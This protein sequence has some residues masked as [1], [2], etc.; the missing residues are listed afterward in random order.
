MNG[1]VHAAGSVSTYVLQMLSAADAQSN[2]VL[3]DTPVESTTPYVYSTSSHYPPSLFAAR[4]VQN[5][6][7]N[8]NTTGNNSVNSGN[9]GN[10]T[11]FQYE[12]SSQYPTTVETPTTTTM[13]H[14]SFGNLG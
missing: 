6:S 7:G 13:K 10:Q 11:N 12:T 3:R 2:G 5:D 9:T 1:A 8:R 14:F 4:N